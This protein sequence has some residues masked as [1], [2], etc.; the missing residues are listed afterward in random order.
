MR[1]VEE[2]P[3]DSIH[4]AYALYQLGELQYWREE[5]EEARAAFAKLV[6]EYPEDLEYPRPG[7]MHIVKSAK[8]SMRLTN[9]YG[10]SPFFDW[11]AF[12]VRRSLSLDRSYYDTSEVWIQTLI[13]QLIALATRMAGLLLALLTLYGLWNT[14]TPL[15]SSGRLLKRPWSLSRM[16]IYLLGIWSLL[17]LGS[18]AR[19][20][21]FSGRASE[22]MFYFLLAWG[23]PI[24]Q[25]IVSG[26]MILIALWGESFVSVFGISRRAFLRT[27]VTLLVALL[28]SLL[29]S[30]IIAR[31]TLLTTGSAELP[32]IDRGLIY[33]RGFH[34]LGSLGVLFL[35]FVG[36]ASEEC[37]F[38][39]VVYETFQ[40]R[41]NVWAA[42]L[43]SSA[44]FA[45]VHV[46]PV[47][48]FVQLFGFGMICAY[49]RQ[50]SASL[51]PGVVLHFFVN[52]L[53]T[54]A[55]T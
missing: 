27:A 33:Q 45:M 16:T 13:L 43:L 41:S 38:R 40:V 2:A 12:R 17:L 6:A 34:T 21:I 42:G 5:R 48:E 37:V 28:V 50:R 54:F 39:G 52:I 29:V 20:W 10:L 18:V 51:L 3:R 47:G 35:V 31:V 53:A 19:L 22:G 24:S 32:Q 49:L 15:R 11:L 9:Y 8:T 14:R 1:V 55:H 46:P 7:G 36:A 30:G 25:F 23:E 4:R 44:L 26:F